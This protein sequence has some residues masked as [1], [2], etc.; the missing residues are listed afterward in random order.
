MCIIIFVLLLVG[1][2]FRLVLERIGKLGFV[3]KGRGRVGVSIRGSEGR[4]SG[5]KVLKGYR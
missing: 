1:G 5:R 2:F 4:F 3:G